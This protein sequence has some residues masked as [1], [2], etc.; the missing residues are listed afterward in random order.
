MQQ[1]LTSVKKID[2]ENGGSIYSQDREATALAHDNWEHYVR[3]RDTRKHQAYLAI[4][5]R[6]EK[7]FIG[8]QWEAKDLERLNKEGRP[9]LTINMILPTVN[10]IVGEQ[11]TRRLDLRVKPGEGGSQETADAIS[12][13]ILSIKQRNDLDWL[14]SRMFQLGVVR[15]R[16]YYDVRMDWTTGRGHITI[17]LEHPADVIPD[18]DS[19]S[20]DPKKWTRCFI[21]R[22]YSL[23]EI[24]TEWGK[25][26]AEA[27]EYHATCGRT[28]GSD[29][30]EFYPPT[31]GNDQG[32]SYEYAVT[33]TDKTEKKRI[34]SV[35]VIEHQFFQYRK[36][37]YLVDPQTG[38][39]RELKQSMTDEEAQALAQRMGAFVYRAME[40][41]MRWRIS[42]DNVLL[43]DGWSN[44]RTMTIIPY[45][46][47]FIEGNPFG[48]IR[49]LFSPQDQLNK[50][51]SQELH[52]INTTA[53]SGWI[54]EQNSLVNMTEDDLNTQGSKTGVTLVYRANRTPPQKIKP[55]TIP[56]GHDRLTAKSVAN[57]K[58]ISGVSDAMLGT[59][60]PEVSGVALEKKQ[61]R[62]LVQQAPL[63]ANLDYTRYLLGEK[64]VELIQDF[65]TDTREVTYV[66]D[67]A[68]G[69]PTESVQLNA[70]TPEGYMHDPT[71][72]EYKVVV[73]TMPSRDNFEDEQ[74][75][76]LLNMR[77]IG[78]NI[79]DYRVVAASNLQNKSEISEELKALA[80]LSEP[81]EEEKQLAAQQQQINMEMQ[82]AA[83]QKLMGEVKELEGR[84]TLH[85]AKAGSEA[86]DADIE[87]S[88]IESQIQI[89]REEFELRKRLAALSAIN[90]L[91][92]IRN[93]STEIQKQSIISSQ[94]KREEEALNSFLEASTQPSSM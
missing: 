29:S 61:N 72:G 91:D 31:F 57:I 89:K 18:P 1:Y 22:W 80:G 37:F 79:P 62:G 50:I 7:Y 52:I 65:Y 16:A 36:V 42:A 4:A 10:S 44:Y 13:T 94:L 47:Y 15:E 84:A 75:A 27:L 51:S 58:V 26:K 48:P 11:T 88:K 33:H 86:K 14:E 82:I 78:I 12:K 60:S 73:S 30:I 87:L 23:E 17:D 43:F 54:V 67:L 49:N 70:P 34:K 55:N 38:D 32:L 20:Y 66:D 45:F 69:Q 68:P 85:M 77:S 81:T 63:K 39:R 53:N 28:Y 24:E 92:S 64:I 3:A 6:S 76:Q 9:A 83:L 19:K 41:R 2:N 21:T 90:K 35:R 56:T 5:D 74:F 46:A 40:R 93:Q 8:E 25:D 59:E 71:I